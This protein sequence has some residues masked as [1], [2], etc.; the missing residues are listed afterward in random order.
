MF[1]EFLACPSTLLRRTKPFVK[2]LLSKFKTLTKIALYMY[3]AQGFNL[4][5]VQNGIHCVPK[6]E[7]LGYVFKY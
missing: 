3:L 7:T 6:V 2:N 4:G 1:A 5:D